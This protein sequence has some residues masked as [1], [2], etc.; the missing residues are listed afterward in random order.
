MFFNRL[1]IYFL[2]LYLQINNGLY[3]LWSISGFSIIILIVTF[4]KNT[5]LPHW[6]FCALLET[7]CAHAFKQLFDSNLIVGCNKAEL[8]NCIQQNFQY[9]D[10]GVVKNYKEKYLQDI[11]SSNTKTCHSPLFDVRRTEG[12]LYLIPLTRNNKYPKK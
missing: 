8:E 7:R 10:R 4:L 5:G 3:I 12:R 9:R 1:Q 11:I 6:F 2:E